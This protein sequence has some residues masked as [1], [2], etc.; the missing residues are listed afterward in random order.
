LASLF[1]LVGC[2][3]VR[4][5]APGSGGCDYLPFSGQC[6]L[7]GAPGAAGPAPDGKG[8]I[9]SVSYALPTTDR[10]RTWDLRWK[11]DAAKVPQLLEHLKQHSPAPCHG[12]YIVR[13]SCTPWSATIDVPAFP[14]AEPL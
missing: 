12:Q 10:P 3:E 7:A 1:A 14:G 2:S 4:P 8:V 6:A 9:V 11:V 13:G 5:P